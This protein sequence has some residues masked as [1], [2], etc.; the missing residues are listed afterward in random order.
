MYGNLY[1]KK[2][3]SRSKCG[4]IC[5]RLMLKIKWILIGLLIQKFTI[6][7]SRGELCE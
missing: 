6:E 1:D 7:L 2:R 5:Y 3:N 4:A